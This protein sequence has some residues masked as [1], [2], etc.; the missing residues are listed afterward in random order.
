VG[1]NLQDHLQLRPIYKVSGVPTMNMMYASVWRRPFM[2]LEYALF[3]R[4]P[5]SMAPSQLGAFAY[6]SPEQA[7]PNLQF[8]VQPPS[9]DKF[10][11]SLHPFAAITLSVCNLRPT[12]RGLVHARSAD[13][14]AAPVIAPHYL[15]T[16]AD[17]RVA[18]DS[19]RLVRRIVE[20]APLAQYH[21]EEYRP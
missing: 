9:L 8:H 16:E 1:E 6:S 2:A 21:P 15:T 11:D 4:G 10:G 3:R 7:T 19:L 12:S 13:A 20:Q 5:L 17:Q 18:V 14:H